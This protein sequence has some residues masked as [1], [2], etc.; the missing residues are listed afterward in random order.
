[1]DD[2]GE[3]DVKE[4]NLGLSA[5]SG[6]F[7]TG[8]AGRDI[9]ASRSPWLHE[10]EAAAQGIALQ[11]TLFDFSD[12]GW[13]DA[14][15]P[16]LLAMAENNGF[17]GLNI[18]FP[19][20]QAVVP[21]LDELSDA[22]RRIG[23][24]NTVRFVDGKRI[25]HN[26]DVSG[27]AESLRIGLPGVTLDH[28]VQIGCGGAGSATAHALIDCGVKTLTMF[29]RDADKQNSLVRALRELFGPD[30]VCAGSDLASAM[31]RAD[32]LVN[33]TPMGMM[34]YPGLPVPAEYISKRH[35]V[36]DI[37]YFPLETS[38]LRE[39]AQKGCRTLNGSGMAVHQAAAA[40]DIFTGLHADRAR[41]L[42]SF[43][44]FVSAS[45]VKVAC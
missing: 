1:L 2:R 15:L 14:D 11:Y 7:L 20:K 12:R 31:A 28:V 25:G 26:T 10:Q 27:F 32:G 39:A 13:S 18:T 34:S 21:F 44:R 17:L 6:G 3:H 45:T 40:F 36:A 16:E 9:L 23:A 30:R 37:V 29:D 8:L 42:D 43:V 22:A 33:S 38:L 41:M 5:G 19:F 24:V 35:W 4:M